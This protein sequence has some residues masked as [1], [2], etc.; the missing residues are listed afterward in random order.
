MAMAQQQLHQIQE[1]QKR[2]VNE[3]MITEKDKVHMPLLM[4]RFCTSKYLSTQLKF[5]FHKLFIDTYSLYIVRLALSP[6]SL[7]QQ[8]FVLSCFVA[9]SLFDRDNLNDKYFF[10]VNTL[11]TTLG[12]VV[13]VAVGVTVIGIVKDFE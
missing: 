7:R 9:C 12:F 4:S 10:V 1:T 2:Q 11:L 13:A 5:N 6:P 3:C 8:C